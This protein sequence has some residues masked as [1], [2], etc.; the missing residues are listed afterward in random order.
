MTRNLNN[1]HAR[2]MTLAALAIG[3]ILAIAPGA[4]AG[5]KV[6]PNKRTL[7]RQQAAPV[8]VEKTPSR[9]ASPVNAARP[10]AHERGNQ[11]GRER[12]RWDDDHRRDGR[13]W[14][15]DRESWRQRGGYRHDRDRDCDQRDR[16]CPEPSDWRRGRDVDVNID[17]DFRGGGVEHRS[18]SYRG[19]VLG[20][21][22]INDHR[23]E[24]RKDHVFE[25]LI[26]A[27]RCAGYE[28]CK[29]K[30]CGKTYIRIYGCPEVCF[31]GYG[32]SLD[33][34]RYHNNVID[35]AVFRDDC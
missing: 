9:D 24:V 26:E 13:E 25:A 16:D 23:V 3:A 32:Y 29:V 6:A 34:I 27:A 1:T 10:A 21:F 2:S 33:V 22:T 28:V 19:N 30:V 7:A 17:I 8:R 11:N 12:G 4:L 14:N 15:N 35:I 31:E 20:T 5:Q 18:H